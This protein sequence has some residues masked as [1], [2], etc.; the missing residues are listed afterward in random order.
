MYLIRLPTTLDPSVLLVHKATYSNSY[1]LK[2]KEKKTQ[3]TALPSP[4]IG[5]NKHLEDKTERNKPLHFII[6]TSI[7]YF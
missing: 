6:A 5:L 7:S 4:K 1:R 2:R 3:K